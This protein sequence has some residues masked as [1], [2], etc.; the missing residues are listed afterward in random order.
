MA[1]VRI[2]LTE[3]EQDMLIKYVSEGVS[4]LGESEDNCEEVSRDMKEGL[5]SALYKINKGRNGQ[6]YY[7]S[8]KRGCCNE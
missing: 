8:Y 6:R 2:Y 5:G 3:K 7:E 4:I 1:G